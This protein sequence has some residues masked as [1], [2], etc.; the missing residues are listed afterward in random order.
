MQAEWKDMEN[1]ISD[2]RKIF[3]LGK[4]LDELDDMRRVI[5]NKAES[6]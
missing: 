5:Q 1:S 2:S 4:F 3:R 6:R